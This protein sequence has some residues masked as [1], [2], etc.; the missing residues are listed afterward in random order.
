MMEQSDG[1][2]SDPPPNRCAVQC[3][4]CKKFSDGLY[5]LGSSSFGSKQEAESAVPVV[6]GTLNGW[7]ARIKIGQYHGAWGVYVKYL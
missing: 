5:V 1:D 6:K 4:K 3:K 7:K 2:S